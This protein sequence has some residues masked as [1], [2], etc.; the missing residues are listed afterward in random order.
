MRRT[1]LIALLLLFL[2]VG[3]FIGYLTGYARG[4]YDSI[5]WGVRVAKPFI[6]VNFD[7]EAIALGIYQYK[8]NIGGCL[9]SERRLNGTMENEETLQENDEEDQPED[10]D[11]DF[12]D[13]ISPGEE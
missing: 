8:N 5:L 7:E 12:D 1:K 4:S 10:P 2:V 11:D 13:R 6:N 3:V 9:F